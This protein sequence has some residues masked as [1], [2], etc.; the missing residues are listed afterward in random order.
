MTGGAGPAASPSCGR[1][2]EGA[3][4]AGGPRPREREL[5][6]PE[7]RSTLI[8]TGAPTGKRLHPMFKLSQETIAIVTVGL[9]ILG[10][11]VYTAT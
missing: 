10:S 7:I 9:T 1:G 5:P 2:H 6:G 4:Q 8:M 3:R 11:N